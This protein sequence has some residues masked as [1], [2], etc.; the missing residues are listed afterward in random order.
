MSDRTYRSIPLGDYQPEWD[1]LCDSL[2]DPRLDQHSYFAI[3]GILLGRLRDRLH[4]LE[5]ND[6]TKT[7]RVN[8][9]RQ[10]LI[11]IKE[12]LRPYWV[13]D[14]GNW[15]GTITGLPTIVEGVANRIRETLEQ[16]DRAVAVCSLLASL[17][18]DSD[19]YLGQSD[20]P[21]FWDAHRQAKALLADIEG[22]TDDE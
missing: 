16:R 22:G 2:D 12:T 7:I 10:C 8:Q 20:Y 3:T 11:E 14:S 17:D 6:A 18:C 5:S 13:D 15:D 19:Q 4:V 9:F 21:T 1:R